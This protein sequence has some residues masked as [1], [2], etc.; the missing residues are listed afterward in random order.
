[1]LTKKYTQAQ[2]FIPLSSFKGFL[3]NYIRI[4]D[5]NRDGYPDISFIVTEKGINTLKILKSIPCSSTNCLERDF[6]VDT[7][8]DSMLEQLPGTVAQ[9]LWADLDDDVKIIS[10][11][12]LKIMEE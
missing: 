11:L 5:Y 9:A 2:P 1:M 7:L 3:P 8:W 12:V 6:V 4:A 10:F